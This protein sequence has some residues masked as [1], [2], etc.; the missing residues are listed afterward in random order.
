[1]R[2]GRLAERGL[3][4]PS[5]ELSAATLQWGQYMLQRTWSNRIPRSSMV[6]AGLTAAILGLLAQLAI[7]VGWVLVGGGLVAAAIGWLTWS[8][9]RL[10][11]AMVSANAVVLHHGDAASG[12]PDR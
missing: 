5:R 2:A 10:A 12:P 11:H 4:A 6:V 9:R 8:Q 1:M 7:G 3:P